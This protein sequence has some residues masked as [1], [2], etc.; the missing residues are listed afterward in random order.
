LGNL[1]HNPWL[2]NFAI[3]LLQEEKE[4]LKLID[5]TSWK[6]K[7]PKSPKTLRMYNYNYHYADYDDYNNDGIIWR[8]DNKRQYLATIDLEST[9]VKDYLTRAGLEL[10]QKQPTKSTNLSKIMKKFREI[11][12]SYSAETIIFSFLIIFLLKMFT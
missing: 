12:D 6:Q 4:V 1:N 3:R 7:F 11:S 5:Q 10:K 9:N 8:R 2:I